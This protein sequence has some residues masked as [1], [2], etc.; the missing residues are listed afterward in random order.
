MAMALQFSWL[1]VAERLGA[2]IESWR[3]R[4]EERRE[5][6][7]DLRLGEKAMKERELVV[8]VERQVLEDHAPIV[9]EPAVVEV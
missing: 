6:R 3:Q 4:R 5:F 1:R 8:E 2:W 7:E 9:I